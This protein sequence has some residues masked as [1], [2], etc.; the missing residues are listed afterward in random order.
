[1]K[2]NL[3]NI[4]KKEL[5]ELF[6]DKKS[7][8]M[9]LIIPIFIPLL[10]IGMSAL[11]EAQVSKDVDEYNNIG[12]AYEMTSVEKSIAEEMNIEII[13]G[14]EEELKQKYNDGEI[15]LYITKDGNKYILN[16]DGS[17]TST[18]SS[19]LME[20]YF[21]TYKQYLQQNYLQENNIDVNE[22]LNIITVE[23]NMIEQ[24]NYFANYIKNYAFL[25]IIMAI[26]VSA[27]Y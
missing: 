18:Y 16:S 11:F 26:T 15:D 13:N 3:W 22:V 24:D 27:T 6:R 25:F 14:N 1:M 19:G 10:V 20:T 9:M 4:L 7:L 2:N 5:R 8:V 21:N 23:E 12:F 17:D